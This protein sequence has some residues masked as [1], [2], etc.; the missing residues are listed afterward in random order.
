[1]DCTIIMGLV[2]PQSQA[3][4]HNKLK[5]L[6]LKPHFKLRKLNHGSNS[7]V[8][9]SKTVQQNRVINPLKAL[10]VCVNFPIQTQYK[11]YPKK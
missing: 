6:L 10:V 1:M 11:H 5:S 7:R 4:Q 9:S 8:L 3:Q 2:Q